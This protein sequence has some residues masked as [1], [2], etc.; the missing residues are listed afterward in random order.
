MSCRRDR[1][2]EYCR[3]TP[4]DH[5]TRFPRE[6]PVSPCP[7]VLVKGSVARQIATGIC[8]GSLALPLSLSSAQ[9][10][11]KHRTDIGRP[12]EAFRTAELLS[13]GGAKLPASRQYRAKVPSRP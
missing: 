12:H 1:P 13:W 2:S 7:P 6:R 4:Y 9:S 10:F 3:P 5:L 11:D 8:L